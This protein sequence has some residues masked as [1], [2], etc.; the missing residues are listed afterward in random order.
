[1]TP[2]FASLQG[3]Y[4]LHYYLCFRT[5]YGRPILSSIDDN[6]FFQQIL[7][8]VSE[9]EAYHML[10]HDISPEGLRLL[11]SLQ[12]NQAVSRAVKMLKGNLAREFNLAF[13]GR[14][15]NSHTDSLWAVGYFV[16]SSGKVNLERA[17]SYVDQQV[18]HHG[19][20]V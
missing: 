16:R 15:Q 1:M 8:D 6:Q 17:R 19:Y 4:P 18:A 9:R 12:P 5:H 11:L 14:L 3:A 2:H 10:N 7:A 13:P 20:R